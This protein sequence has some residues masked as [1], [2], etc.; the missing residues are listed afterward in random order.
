[1]FSATMPPKIRDLAKK[2]TVKRE[3]EFKS[4]QGN[5]DKIRGNVDKIN[6]ERV[7]FLKFT[8]FFHV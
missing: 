7:K 5:H 4:E 2:I 8:H 3:M 6:R 1:M